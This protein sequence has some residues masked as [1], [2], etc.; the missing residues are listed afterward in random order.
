MS[1]DRATSRQTPYEGLRENISAVGQLRGFL[2]KYS[3]SHLEEIMRAFKN[4]WKKLNS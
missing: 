3:W 2:E 1:G 4:H